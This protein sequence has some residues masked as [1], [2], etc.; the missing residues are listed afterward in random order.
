MKVVPAAP[1]CSSRRDAQGAGRTGGAGRQRCCQV[2][3]STSRRH[4]LLVAGSFEW[5]VHLCCRPPLP[6][7]PYPH[8]KLLLKS[9]PL[10]AQHNPQT[11]CSSSSLNT[12]LDLGCQ[13]VVCL[14]LD[15]ALGCTCHQA[16]R[17]IEQLLHGLAAGLQ[18]LAD[19]EHLGVAAPV[20]LA[21]QLG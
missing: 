16:I 5:S 18:H 10:S 8:V 19:G 17:A 7:N 9:Q 20:A 11:N 1:P 12:H 6:Q 2:H 15:G 14:L 4:L 3:R 13:E 21:G